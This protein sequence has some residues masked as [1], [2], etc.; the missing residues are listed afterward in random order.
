MNFMKTLPFVDSRF[1]LYDA[2]KVKTLA[3]KIPFRSIEVIDKIE[4]VESKSG[5]MV[6]REYTIVKFTK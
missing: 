3:S 2:N 4:T 6:N 1:E 5:D